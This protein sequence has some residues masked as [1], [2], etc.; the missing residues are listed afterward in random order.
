M[1]III[2]TRVDN[3]CKS[4]KTVTAKN[5]F[6]KARRQL[7]ILLREKGSMASIMPKRRRKRENYARRAKGSKGPI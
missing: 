4:K 5:E 6:H 7:R 2:I 3:N 1:G